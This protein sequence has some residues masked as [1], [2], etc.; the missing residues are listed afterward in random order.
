MNRR[1]FLK[2][3]AAAGAAAV[4]PLS[5]LPKEEYSF[6]KKN[7]GTIRLK[8]N[9]FIEV[10]TLPGAQNLGGCPCNSMGTCGVD[11]MEEANLCPIRGLKMFTNQYD[12]IIAPSQQKAESI[13]AHMMYG[14]KVW[15]KHEMPTQIWMSYSETLDPDLRLKLYEAREDLWGYSI[16]GPAEAAAMGK[17]KM[18]P[19]WMDEIEGD[20]WVEMS[21]DAKFEVWMETD[22]PVPGTP[23]KWY[24]TETKTVRE[25][26]GEWGEGYFVSTE[27]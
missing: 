10:E 11:S 1:E 5:I 7:G 16:T 6:W 12:W 21:M 4:L 19:I 15:Q 18:Y 27:W 2:G 23:Q 17:T 24:R 25:W 8:E 14:H 22:E 26:I 9:D 20:G 3:T 13:L